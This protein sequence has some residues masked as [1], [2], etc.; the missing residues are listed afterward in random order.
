MD[1]R[2]LKES[3]FHPW[4]YGFR[5]CIFL[6]P[7]F[8]SDLYSFQKFTSMKPE[9]LNCLNSE[10][11]VSTNPNGLFLQHTL[12]CLGGHASDLNPKHS[13]FCILHLNTNICL[14]FYLDNYLVI[15]P[16]LKFDLSWSPSHITWNFQPTKQG[17]SSAHNHPR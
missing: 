16:I 4:D 5:P 13:L 1:S 9:L 17:I 2:D 7:N 14:Q 3:Q 6:R 10:A 12:G 11:D 8:C 15:S